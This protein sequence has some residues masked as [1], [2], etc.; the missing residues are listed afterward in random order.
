MQHLP[1]PEDMKALIVDS[2][3]LER[4]K[5][6]EWLKQNGIAVK[7]REEFASFLLYSIHILRAELKNIDGQLFLSFLSICD[8][9]AKLFISTHYLHL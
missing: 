3:F 5:G 4:W 2:F 8:S 6:G 7:Q 9:V 1:L